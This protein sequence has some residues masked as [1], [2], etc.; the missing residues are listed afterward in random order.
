MALSHNG[1]D[2]KDGKTTPATPDANLG[3][4]PYVHD[5]IN[6]NGVKTGTYTL[7]IKPDGNGST[8]ATV[9]SIG[10]VTGTNIKRLHHMI[11]AWLGK[12]R[13]KVLQSIGRMLRLHAEKEAE[14]AILYD[15]VDDLSTKSRQNYALKHFAQRCLI[16]DSEE[17]EYKIYN[18]GLK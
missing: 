17:F 1:A 14:G 13:I 9:R 6:D 18:I 12:G 7:W 16:Y 15:I 10:Q 8:I 2:F 4:G 5:Y 3:Y 11:S